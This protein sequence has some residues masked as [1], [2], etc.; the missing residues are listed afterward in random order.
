MSNDVYV[1]VAGWVAKKPDLRVTADKTEWTTVR[2]ANTPRRR[3]PDGQ[4]TDGKTEWY[5]VKAWGDLAQNVVKSVDT[6]HPVIVYGR[7]SSDEWQTSEGQDRKNLVINAQIIGHDLARGRTDFIRVRHD[8]AGEPVDVSDAVELPDAPPSAP[9][10]DDVTAPEP[11]LE[12]A[13]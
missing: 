4:W 2:V 11:E 1:T 12:P 13:F 5:E 6:G 10:P 9:T 8:A 3:K 7:L